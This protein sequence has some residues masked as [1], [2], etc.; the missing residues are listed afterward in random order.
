MVR[1]FHQ[2][3]TML[4]LLPPIL[5]VIVALWLLWTPTGER[6]M[7]GI[8]MAIVSIMM[9][10]R[11]IHTQ[12]TLTDDGLLVISRGR[13]S[14]R[15]TICI[16]EITSVE[17]FSSSLLRPGFILLHYGA[18]HEIAIRPSNSLAFMAELRKR[19]E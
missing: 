14:V 2:Q 16:N 6:I 3:L 5:C 17:E 9:T 18:G 1:T 13:L 7:L 15:K 4:S 12:Y 19:Q 8:A 10:E 11:T